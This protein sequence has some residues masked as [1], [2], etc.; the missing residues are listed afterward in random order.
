MS[1]SR[2]N[3]RRLLK[4]TAAA[5]APY[6]ITST[7]LGN[8]DTP[9]ASERVTLGHIGMGNR[10][11]MGQLFSEFQSCKS[12][13]SVAVA[14]ALSG[15][16][17][18]LCAGMIKGKAYRDF[19]DLLARND[20]DAVVVCHARPLARAD[21]HCRCAGEKRRL[22]G[23]AVGLEH[24]ARPCLPEGRLRRQAGSFSTAR[25]SARRRILPIRLRTGPQRKIGKVHTIEVV[26]PNGGAGGST[27]VVPVPPTLDYHMWCGPGAAEALHGRPLP[28]A[29]NLLDLRLLDRISCRL[30]RPPAGHHGLGERLPIWPGRSWSRGR[31][32][33]RRRAS[34]TRSTI[35]T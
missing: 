1:G 11:G 21:R 13:Q 6:V 28:S 16:P 26:A 35:G 34:T 29:G 31:R 14:D 25:S 20:I 9:P 2:F 17:R 10:G 12:A 8:A 32:W 23:K 7:A 4:A 18:V 33:F 30:G 22:R 24:R 19:R 15:S 5:A 27:Q 3:R